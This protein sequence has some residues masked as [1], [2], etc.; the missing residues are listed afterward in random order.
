[1]DEENDYKVFLTLK[2]KVSKEKEGSH[3]FFFF[4]YINFNHN[5]IHFNLCF[6]L[7]NFMELSYALFFNF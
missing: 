2:S 3:T 6:F 4:T 1:M 7:M 5:S